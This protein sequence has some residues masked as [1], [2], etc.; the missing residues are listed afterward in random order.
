MTAET[1]AGAEHFGG[2]FGLEFREVLRVE[3]AGEDVF[4]VVRQA[5]IGG[6]DAV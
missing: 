6:K 3:D 5:M 1:G 2:V 4:D